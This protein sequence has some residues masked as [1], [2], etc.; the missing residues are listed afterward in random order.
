MFEGKE[1][2][3]VLCQ[4]LDETMAN[5]PKVIV[6]DAD[7]AKANGTFNLRKKYPD[8]AIDVGIAEQNM[9][10]IAAGMASYGY[11]PFILSFTPFATRRICDQIAISICYAKQNVKIIGTDPGISAEFNG[12]TH[13]SVEDIG[14]LRSIPNLV[15]YEPV[16]A[17]QLYKSLPVILEY[18]GP[19]YIRMFRKVIDPVFDNNYSFDLFKADVVK[20]GIDVTILATGIMVKEALK[21]SELLKEEGIDVEVINVHTIKPLDE[22]TIMNSLNKTK[23]CVV[24]ENHNLIGG[25][26]SAVSELLC[27]KMP[28]KITKVGIPDRFGEVGKMPYLKEVMGMT[29]E[30]IIS[31]IKKALSYK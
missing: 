4:F 3:Q 11:K 23:A 28:M 8:R 9:A 15:I 29:N 1:M 21:V 26:Y 27:E 30:N 2:R 5:D 20:E 12:G 17:I 16:D 19:I 24:L 25:L 22:E 13:M 7:L 6:I 18:N 14:V 10:S 31:A